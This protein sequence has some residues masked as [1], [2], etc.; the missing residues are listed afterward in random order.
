MFKILIADDERFIRKGIIAILKRGLEE[1]IQF[2]EAGN[3][4][5]AIDLAQKEHFHLVI[6]DISMPGSSGLE[7]I[8]A[9]KD[10]G[11]TATVIILSGYENF[12]YAREAV[13][14]GVREYVMKPVKKPEFLELVRTCLEETRQSRSSR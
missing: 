9:L 10:S 7:F 4:I 11:Q 12:E 13:R 6:S 3:G 1:E 14:L 2:V 8:K 5:E